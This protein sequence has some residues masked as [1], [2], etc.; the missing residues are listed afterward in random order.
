MGIKIMG[1]DKRESQRARRMN[2]N[3]QLAGVGMGENL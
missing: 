3:L 1:R 2:G